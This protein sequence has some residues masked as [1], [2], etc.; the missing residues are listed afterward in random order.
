MTATTETGEDGRRVTRAAVGGLELYRL[1]FP[2]AFRHGV[3]DPPHGY[4]AVVLEGA[5]C[6]S[7]R[8]T[9]STLD[10]GSFA[11][12]PA[13]AAHS[14]VFAAAG[15]EILVIRPANDDG[16]KLF[17][18][19]FLELRRVDAAAAVHLGRRIAGELDA[20]DP[21]SALALEGLALEL[22]ASAGRAAAPRVNR[23][24]AW[25]HT[26]R[27][28]LDASIPGD[29]CLQELAGSVGR[30]PAHVARVFR[31][32][33]GVSVAD[34]A[35]LRRLEWATAQIVSTDVALARIA[36]DAG[37]ADQSHFTRAFRRHHGVTPG[38]YREV[39]R[40]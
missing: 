27:E 4:L 11:S 13:G 9:M 39:V 36:L 23:D 29:P 12:I 32:E 38:R 15:C 18:R 34:Y 1:L 26:V 16:A 3:I 28:L 7:F 19:L 5:V 20:K 17:G 2:P 21:C 14:S 22:I 8:Q 24:A 40:A 35:R 33:Y 37:F 6:K 30:H 31:R 25:V 10:R